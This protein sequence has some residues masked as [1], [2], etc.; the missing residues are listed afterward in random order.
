MSRTP[1]FTTQEASRILG[2]PETLIAKWKHR[3]KITPAGY[4]RGR[5]NNA[6]LYKLDEIRPLAEAYL[7]ASTRRSEA[8][9][10]QEGNP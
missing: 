1:T 5:G 3:R 9:R 2:V 4:I 7:E 10:L 6:P 8:N